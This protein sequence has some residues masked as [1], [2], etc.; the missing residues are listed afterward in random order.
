MAFQWKQ[1]IRESQLW[2]GSGHF[3]RREHSSKDWAFVSLTQAPL[4]PD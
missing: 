1:A 3:V 4:C 2:V